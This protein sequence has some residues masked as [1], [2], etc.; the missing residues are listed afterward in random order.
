MKNTTA[1]ECLDIAD[2]II[3]YFKE[4]GKKYERELFPVKALHDQNVTQIRLMHSAGVIDEHVRCR[5]SGF[6]KTVY[7]QLTDLS[8]FLAMA[9]T[10]VV[11]RKVYSLRLTVWGNFFFVRNRQTVNRQL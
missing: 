5:L 10:R 9:F 7:L 3:A 6:Q 8:R 4:N 11:L 2:R 1:K